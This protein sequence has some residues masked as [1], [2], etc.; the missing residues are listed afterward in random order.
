MLN[1]FTKKIFGSSNDRLLKKIYPLVESTNLLEK[2]FNTLKDEDLLK[3]TQELK[4]RVKKE[5]KL[6]ILFLKHLQM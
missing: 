2:K 6:M 4:N 1:Y 5:K 3:K